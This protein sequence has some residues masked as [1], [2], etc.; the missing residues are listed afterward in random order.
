MSW[1][2]VVSQVSARCHSRGLRLT[3]DEFHVV[4]HKLEML[5][6]GA[7]RKMASAFDA[8]ATIIGLARACGITRKIVFRPSLSRNAEVRRRAQSER[9]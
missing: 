3:V 4:R 1:N 7:K 8:L 6:P 9:R 5:L 2:S